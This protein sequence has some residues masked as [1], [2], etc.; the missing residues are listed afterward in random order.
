MEKD[1]E[2][3][4]D[5]IVHD[6]PIVAELLEIQKYKTVQETSQETSL[7]WVQDLKCLSLAK[8]S[9]KRRHDQRGDDGNTRRKVL[10]RSQIDAFCEQ[11]YVAISYT[12]EAGDGEDDGKEKYCILTEGERVQSKVRDAVLDRAIKYVDYKNCSGFWIDQECINQASVREKEVAMQ[13]MDLVY[14][15][16]DC[17]VALLCVRIDSGGELR[18]LTELLEGRLTRGAGD[19][20][21]VLKLLERITGD[22]WW[23]RAWTYQEEYRASTRM[24]LLVSHARF[25]EKQKDRKRF[26]DLV[27]ELCINSVEFRK[28][29]TRICR[30]YLTDDALEE[31]HRRSCEVILGRAA[32][33]K[34]LLGNAAGE[35]DETSPSMSPLVLRDIGTR[36]ITHPRDILAIAANCCQYAVRLN[37]AGLDTTNCSL[38]VALLAL[39]VLNGE[40]LSNKDDDDDDM[41]GCAETNIFGLLRKMSIDTYRPPVHQR[42]SFIKG[43]RFIDV[44]LVDEGVVTTGHLWRLGKPSIRVRPPCKSRSEG[45]TISGLTGHHRRC[46]QKLIRELKTGEHG[47]CYD[48]LALE[49]EDYLDTVTQ[50]SGNS[51]TFADRYKNLMAVELAEAIESGKRLRLGCLVD[52]RHY[53]AVFVDDDIWRDGVPEYIFTSSRPVRDH[54]SWRDLDK[55]VSLKVTFPDH[56]RQG[57]PRLFIDKWV[58]GLLFFKGCQTQKVLFPWPASLRS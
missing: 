10:E 57:R 35:D 39:F 25:L 11:D 12:H 5:E 44:E 48:P 29:T 54:D 22:R 30:A 26:G 19:L 4:L 50:S 31:R 45:R 46:L 51:L 2:L 8:T 24:V 17:P 23:N 20:D 34:E 42:L 49:L 14:S 28:R 43:C 27:G 16:S 52:K 36:D 47:A 1:L 18:T 40:I 9:N 41:T 6:H 55:Y 53:T 37:T 56:M 13:S 3:H 21:K 58:N 15:L 32:R 33:Y 7:T 38:S